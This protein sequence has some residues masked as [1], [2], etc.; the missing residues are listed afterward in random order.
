MEDSS[1]ALRVNLALRELL[2]LAHDVQQALARRLALGP[3]DVQ[4]LQHLA[5]GGPMGTVD[6][7]H[8]LKI[9]SASATVL[10]DR[11]ESAGHVRRGP[12]PS[13]RRRITLTVTEP[14]RAEIRAALA[15]LV[16]AITRLTEGLE[17]DHAE[18]V[19]RFLGATTEILRTYAAG[20]AEPSGPR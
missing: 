14:A 16:D 6:L 8:A 11:L 19:A 7:A 10:V 17:P 13:D 18:S 2:A 20:P 5:G 1:V 9:R 3:T 4:A 15:P 12:H